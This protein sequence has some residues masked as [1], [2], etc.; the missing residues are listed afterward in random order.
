MNA[1]D[2]AG[3]TPLMLAAAAGAESFRA[4]ALETI[5][6]LAEAG[7]DFGAK[8]KKKRTVL[9]WIE[10][11]HG[12][13][14]LKKILYGELADMIG[15]TF[16]PSRKKTAARHKREADA[17]LMIA[18]CF[19][20]AEEIEKALESGANVNV[21]GNKGHAPLIFA[22]VFNTPEAVKFLIGRGA[23]LKARNFRGETVL[24]VAVQSDKADPGIVRALAEAGMDVNI[25]DD[26]GYTPLMLAA[27][28]RNTGSIAKILV[29][30]GADI[31]IKRKDDEG[32]EKDA[33][34]I[35]M[36]KKHFHVVRALLA[37]GAE[38][39][40]P[41]EDAPDSDGDDEYQYDEDETEEDGK[42]E[43]FSKTAIMLRQHGLKIPG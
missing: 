32:S 42:G 22:S 16:K 7:A 17:N 14:A 24:H 33:L 41:N 26:G 31:G 27:R 38:L 21:R 10:E 40:A 3:I 43:I 9:S 30:A 37:A 2:K 20:S 5:R 39:P 25:T 29:D 34:S 12:A 1:R 13:E 18:S 35:A 11:S 36:N 4:D 8:D 19:G 6:A 28:V 23:D 15:Q